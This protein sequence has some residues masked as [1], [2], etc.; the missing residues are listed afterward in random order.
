MKR[1]NIHLLL[2]TFFAFILLAG[3]G[4]EETSSETLPPAISVKTVTVGGISAGSGI[5]YSGTVQPLQ[6]ANIAS[7]FMGTVKKIYVSEGDFVRQGEALIRLESKEMDARLAQADAGLAAAK[8]AYENAKKNL[9]RFEAL[10]KQGAA[11]DNELENIRLAYQNAE[12]MK[13]GAVAQRN[14]VLE[15]MKHVHIV[16]PF[17]GIVSK[18]MIN[19]GDL[20]TPGRPLLTLESTG[21]FKLEL[22]IAENDISGL[23]AKQPVSVEVPAAGKGLFPGVISNIV[24]AADPAS[25]QFRIKILLKKANVS[26]KPGMFARVHFGAVGDSSLYIPLSAVIHRGELTGV[27]VVDAQK[28]ARLRW[29][30]TGA[31]KNNV[32]EALAGLN[33]GE[34]IIAN[35]KA[36]LVDGQPVEVAR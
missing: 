15:M 30:R 28:R 21:K 7:K 36:R 2:L 16:A 19:V 31:R 1:V 13:K 23:S 24:R 10:H 18:K 8:I 20:A 34:E 3:C 35:G 6:R 27:F 29:I 12:A 17:S 22:D 5:T 25:H 9:K 4:K 26:L 32:I 11:T 14:Q 33:P